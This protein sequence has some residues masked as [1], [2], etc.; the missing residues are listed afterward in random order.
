VN[1]SFYPSP[2][3]SKKPT[4]FLSIDMWGIEGEYADGNWHTLLHRF[5]LDWSNAHPDQ[6]TATLWS[7]VQPCAL[8]NSGSSCYVA[9]SSKLPETFFQQLVSFLRLNFGKHA[10]VGGEIQ[11]DL[12][13]WRIYMHFENGGV[14]EKDDEDE[15]RILEL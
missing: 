4:L 3:R 13:E 9:G 5:A 2:K 12:D 7:S 8:F 6:E 10:L 15:W 14:W 1:E 11:V